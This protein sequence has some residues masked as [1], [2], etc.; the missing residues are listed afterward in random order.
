[1]VADGGAD[2]GYV[3]IG[4]FAVE[5][6]AARPLDLNRIVLGAQ[7]KALQ[8]EAAGLARGQ[9]GGEESG[10]GFGQEGETGRAEFE[11]FKEVRERG[12]QGFEMPG[13]VVATAAQDRFERL[14][15]FASPQPA[16]PQRAQRP[17][18]LVGARQCADDRRDGRLVHNRGQFGDAALEDDHAPAFGDFVWPLD[19]GDGRRVL[20]PLC[21][22][23]LQRH[24]DVVFTELIRDGELFRARTV[25]VGPPKVVRRVAG[26]EEQ[27]AEGASP[28]GGD[29]RRVETVDE[30]PQRVDGARLVDGEGLLGVFAV[31]VAGRG[32]AL[33]QAGAVQRGGLGDLVGALHIE[34]GDGF[35]AAL[36]AGRALV[37]AREGREFAFFPLE[38]AGGSLLSAVGTFCQVE[39]LQVCFESFVPLFCDG[40]VGQRGLEFGLAW[41]RGGQFEQEARD[42]IVGC[43]QHAVARAGGLRG[44][45]GGGSERV[46]DPLPGRSVKR[47]PVGRD[48][49][50]E[51]RQEAGQRAVARGRRSGD[52]RDVEDAHTRSITPPNNKNQS[53]KR[54]SENTSQSHQD[55]KSRSFCPFVSLGLCAFVIKIPGFL[56]AF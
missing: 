48:P 13:P 38:G 39:R 25:V 17:E 23:G 54:V 10:F 31:G 43:H 53:S 2:D 22:R 21:Q 28:F 52:E 40:Q 34:I 42:G 33:Q 5:S 9:R 36:A 47:K 30:R 4:K 24:P 27:R 46:E 32:D 19:N 16:G 56:D 49:I 44:Q 14:G 7:G 29:A 12:L 3:C 15:G 50:V 37:E 20:R 18:G 51:R 55:T 26:R 41:R 11:Q 1:M 8:L 6:L 45:T 35:H